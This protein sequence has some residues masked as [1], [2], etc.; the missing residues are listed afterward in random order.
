LPAKATI[1]TAP[2]WELPLED[3]SVDLIVTSPPYWMLREYRDAGKPIEGQVGLEPTWQE[4]LDNLVRC[5]RE[6]V[7]VLKPSGSL[8]VNL[9][10]KYGRGTRTTVHGG[11][12]KQ[13]YVDG[14]RPGACAPTGYEKSL[15]GLPWRY[16]IRCTDE[17]GLVNRA[18]V[19][20]SKVNGLPESVQDRV[21]RSHEQFF[22]FTRQERYYHAVDDIRLPYL[23]G[24]FAANG[25]KGAR[26]SGTRYSD[27]RL[28]TNYDMGEEMEANPRGRLPGSVWEVAS[29][30]LSIPDYLRGDLGEELNHYAAFPTRLIRPIVKA[31]CPRDICSK[32]GQGRFP[33]TRVSY[34]K[35]NNV[36]SNKYVDG[37]EADGTYG[38]GRPGSAASGQDAFRM[39]VNVGYACACTPYTDHPARRGVSWHDHGDDIGK[40][41]TQLPSKRDAGG[42]IPMDGGQVRANGVREPE[43]PVREYHFDR[44]EPAPSAP[45]TVLDPFG[46]TG[47]SAL[48]AVVHG[49]NG[50]SSDL[51]RDYSRIAGWR[52]HDGG[53]RARAL[54]EKKAPKGK[55]VNEYLYG[56]LFAELDEMLG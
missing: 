55:R 5:T 15:V 13:A 21:R 33:V 6:W 30:P 3:E 48:V 7:R 32:C 22:H 40:G 28:S 29:E 8:W 47:T 25:Q 45:G 35:R 11:N 16:A 34:V 23:D 10:D 26:P 2:A 42:A 12:S 18:E 31:W 19:I 44:W 20:W 24:D 39:S 27:E 54:G 9:G 43:G 4:Y 53:E 52:V 49:R 41:Q 51:S 56:D 37:L 38:K 46:G 50:I 1:I 17:L 36:Y 14:D